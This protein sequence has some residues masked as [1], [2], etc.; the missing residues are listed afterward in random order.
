MVGGGN[1]VIEYMCPIFNV[2]K[3]WNTMPEDFK[4][5]SCYIFENI[6]YLFQNSTP[7]VPVSHPNVPAMP[8]KRSRDALSPML[9]QRSMNVEGPQ[10][11]GFGPGGTR[12]FPLE[13]KLI[14]SIKK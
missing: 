13:A 14:V 2:W 11:P 1:N 10:M 3:I 7:N 8:S 4:Y 5:N 12:S 9:R 6:L